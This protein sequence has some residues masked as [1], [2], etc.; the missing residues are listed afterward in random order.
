MSTHKS[1]LESLRIS[2]IDEEYI[3]RQNVDGY[4]RKDVIYVPGDAFG[5]REKGTYWECVMDSD[6]R[7]G[8]TFY[9]KIDTVTGQKIPV[10]SAGRSYF[11]ND[12]KNMIT[13]GWIKVVPIGT[14]IQVKQ[15]I[16]RDREVKKDMMIGQMLRKRK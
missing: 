6:K 3:V 10:E 2:R 1:I 11:K 14:K 13:M 5:E 7:N 15:E 16:S 8:K 12:I 4:T 9:Q